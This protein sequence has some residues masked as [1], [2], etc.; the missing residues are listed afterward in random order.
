MQASSVMN[1]TIISILIHLKY[2]KRTEQAADNFIMAKA[3]VGPRLTVLFTTARW[4]LFAAEK[5]ELETFVPLNPR[6]LCGTAGKFSILFTR[7]VQVNINTLEFFLFGFY[8][9]FWNY[10]LFN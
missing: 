10:P 9:H 3:D 2:G 8:F 5:D 6:I 7:Q 4:S 1:E